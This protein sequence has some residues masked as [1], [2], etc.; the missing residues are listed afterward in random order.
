MRASI[1][2]ALLSLLASSCTRTVTCA[3]EPGHAFCDDAGAR[4][5]GPPDGGE[6]ASALDAGPRDGG[7]DAAARDAGAC[8][9]CD[10][11]RCVDGGCVEC[12]AETEDTDC[13]VDAP[14]CNE[15]T[16]ICVACIANEDCSNATRPLC[17][18]F[19]CRGCEPGP[20]CAA[21]DASRPVCLGTGECVECTVSEPDAC[22]G[23]PCTTAN[24]CSAY[25]AGTRRACES[26]DTDA[27]CADAEH[28]CVPMQ[29][30][31]VDRPGGYCLEAVSAG[32]E[33]PFSI[34]TPVRATLSEVTGLTFCGINETLAT[35]EAVRALLD[36]QPCPDGNDDECPE[37]GLCRTVGVLPDRCTYR[38]SNP[39]QCMDP[40]ESPGRSTCGDGAP[41]VPP[42][43]CGG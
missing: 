28:Y 36:N 16:G 43:H 25:V 40:T 37:S 23:N 15:A 27:S 8:A 24:R 30:A 2:L 11:G 22:G 18:D 12:T 10:A 26:C 41:D 33:Q 42:D 9:A 38:C 13:D 14:R 7:E 32:C 39:E 20:E 19:A 31:G 6:D 1:G 3:E 34:A 29:Y 5:A 35:C 4:D 17:V 21:F